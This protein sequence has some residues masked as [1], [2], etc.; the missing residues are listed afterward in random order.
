MF[1]E[2]FLAI[3]VEMWITVRIHT[4]PYITKISRFSWRQQDNIY[5]QKTYL[6]FTI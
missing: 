5:A 2:T 3:I 6:L 1:Q 4:S